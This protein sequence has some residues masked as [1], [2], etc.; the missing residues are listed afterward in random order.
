MK[1]KDNT[2]YW[3]LILDSGK[4]SIAEHL[5]SGQFQITGDENLYFEKDLG[6]IGE[7]IPSTHELLDIKRNVGF[8]EVQVHCGNKTILQ[9]KTM[10]LTDAKTKLLGHDKQVKYEGS[11]IEDR[12]VSSYGQIIHFKDEVI[13]K[14]YYFIK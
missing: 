12:G 2:Y 7:E 6:Q 5:N 14:S 13:V 3:I 11:V 4:W 1:L 10:T 9:G 8:F